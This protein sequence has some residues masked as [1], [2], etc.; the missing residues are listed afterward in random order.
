MEGKQQ[1]LKRKRGGKTSVKG[2]QKMEEEETEDK[3]EGR[4]EG[5]GRKH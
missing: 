5:N 4:K 3:D 2:R 1:K